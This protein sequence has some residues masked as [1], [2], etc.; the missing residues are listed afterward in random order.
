MRLPSLPSSTPKAPAAGASSSASSPSLDALGTFSGRRLLLGVLAAAVT[1]QVLP[2]AQR[3]AAPPAPPALSDDVYGDAIPT[4]DLE[5][6]LIALADAGE[7]VPPPLLAA[8]EE[9]GGPQLFASNGQGKWTLPWVGNWRRVWTSRADGRFG[10]APVVEGG[11]RK[12]LSVQTFVYGPG[13]DAVTTEALYAS[14]DGSRTV[15]TRLGDV[16]NAGGNY[17]DLGFNG[18]QA[19]DVV[20]TPQGRDTL[21]AP[22]GVGG[23]GA[24]A[25]ADTRTLH[26]TYL[27]ATMWIQRDESGE[28]AVYERS[29][30]FAVSDRRGLV[31]PDQLKEHP[32]E[33]TRYG[34]LL[35]SEELTGDN[36]Q[37]EG[38][39]EKATNE[40]KLRQ[41]LFK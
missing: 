8:L 11:G 23:G 9:Y 20:R 12:L 35:F 29:E 17:F 40:A 26:T 37:Y 13:K 41:K 15:F 2:K 38:W 27:S 1:T 25:N 10:G 28:V 3:L 34:K 21:G 24:L 5:T 14:P 30:A 6:K 7:A 4:P 32:D 36:K 39:E 22:T 18:V 33:F 16:E 19:Y 31:I